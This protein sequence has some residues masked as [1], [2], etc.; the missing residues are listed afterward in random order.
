MSEQTENSMVLTESTKYELQ[1][2]NESSTTL[3]APEVKD[4]KDGVN[5]ENG[6]NRATPT[7]KV[8][9]EHK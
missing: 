1:V 9:P 4:I 8:I 2:S 6:N 7:V 3:T 5:G